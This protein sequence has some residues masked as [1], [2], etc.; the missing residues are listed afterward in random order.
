M[1]ERPKLPTSLRE[2]P[3]V[4]KERFLE[5]VFTAVIYRELA[6]IFYETLDELGHDDAWIDA[7]KDEIL[8]LDPETTIAMFAIPEDVKER[9][10]GIQSK[11]K[12]PHD[13]IQGL[14]QNV[15]TYHWRVGYHASKFEVQKREGT[16]YSIIG[17]E[18]DHRDNDLAR[19]YYSTSYMSIYRDKPARFLYVIRAET[20]EDSSHRKDND[21]RNW[22]RASTL[23]IVTRLDITKIHHEIEQKFAAY[24]RGAAEPMSTTPLTS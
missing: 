7:V 19:A 24:R 8:S 23:P 1:L 5:D 11:G 15:E 20:G 14:V 22:S 9:Y 12:N 3:K 13:F 21:G 17:K 6:D 10:L 2:V 18:I 16:P 4:E